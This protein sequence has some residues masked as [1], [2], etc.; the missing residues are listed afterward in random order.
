MG[1]GFKGLARRIDRRRR[2]S[3]P[4]VNGR[5]PR[6][7]LVCGPS[8]PAS[9]GR[10]HR[11]AIAG[12]ANGAAGDTFQ[13]PAGVNLDWTPGSGAI[14]QTS[15][16]PLHV[17]DTLTGIPGSAPYVLDTRPAP[18]EPTCRAPTGTSSGSSGSIP[19][20]RRFRGP[21]SRSVG[22]TPRSRPRCDCT[23][24]GRSSCRVGSGRSATPT[25]RSTSGL[26]GW[27]PRPRSG[28]TAVV[29]NSLGLALDPI[30]GGYHIH[31][32]VTTS[33]FTVATG[34]P[35]P[36][37]LEVRL[38]TSA[39]A[40]EPS[41]FDLDFSDGLTFA[42]T[43]QVFVLPAGFDANG[44]GIVGNQWIQGPPTA[45]FSVTPVN[46]D[47]GTA[48][49]FDG[50]AS[51]APP[52]RTIVRYLWD[53]DDGSGVE[54]TTAPT[55]DHAF[56]RLGLLHPTLTVQDDLGHV[57]DA[58]TTTA[59]SLDRGAPTAVVTG[60]AI[61]N[62]GATVTFDGSGSSDPEAG[63]GSRLVEWT[64]SLDGGA[65]IVTDTPTIDSSRFG[66][67]DQRV[68]HGPPRGHRRQRQRERPANFAF[69][70]SSD[71]PRSCGLADPARAARRSP[72]TAR[73]RSPTRP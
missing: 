9:G 37:E 15:T 71:R 12:V 48:V 6:V 57:S 66:S 28:R 4:A 1:A 25:P 59:R 36:V 24:T 73:P 58:A 43:G 72:S 65:A 34:S 42:P 17:E 2:S 70:S 53:Y 49:R 62:L 13:V 68:A 5:S 69:G 46:S 47:C 21:S 45:A 26:A 40:W 50:S 18:C 38:I 51:T 67:P 3:A 16:E 61:A 19:A 30:T 27:R 22:R 44:T 60:P 11:G 31:G 20:S 10:A 55:V 29:Q 8:W 64:W 54:S 35:F 39:R 52:G 32:D 14:S 41:I 23:S 7:I 63:C 56:A 33:T